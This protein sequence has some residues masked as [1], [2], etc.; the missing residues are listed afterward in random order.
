MFHYIYPLRYIYIS[1][2]TITTIDFVYQCDFQRAT[3]RKE[4]LF[5]PYFIQ[6]TSDK[7]RKL[8]SFVRL[9][10]TSCPRVDYGFKKLSSMWISS[11]L[12]C[13]FLITKLFTFSIKLELNLRY[14]YIYISIDTISTVDFVYQCDFQIAMWSSLLH[15]KDLGLEKKTYLLR[16][17]S[18]NQLSKSWLWILK[19]FKH[20]NFINTYLFIFTLF[21]ITKLFIF[22]IKLELN[23]R[24]II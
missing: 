2:D 23:L 17:A 16:Q 20:A 24:Y 22:F 4:N 18:Y 9:H 12:I 7:K 6:K 14:I 8:A 5:S 13:L 3:W 21:V 10:T 15:S 19:T 11:T 1:I